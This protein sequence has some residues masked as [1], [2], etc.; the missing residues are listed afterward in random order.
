MTEQ[1]CTLIKH[2]LKQY[3][4]I[5]ISIRFSPAL[6]ILTRDQLV[7]AIPRNVKLA[8]FGAGP[9]LSVG[10]APLPPR[11]ASQEN[12]NEIEA[13]SVLEQFRKECIYR[14]VGIGSGT[15][16]ESESESKSESPL[17]LRTALGRLLPLSP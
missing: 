6:R 7:R 17:N 12:K 14:W 9:T 16:L 8:D 2:W 15:V 1:S 10:L 5:G 13:N 4:G 3:F 11:H